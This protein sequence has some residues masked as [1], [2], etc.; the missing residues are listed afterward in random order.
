MPPKTK[1]QRLSSTGILFRISDTNPVKN[2]PIMQVA[3][4]ETVLG[5]LTPDCQ[6]YWARITVVGTKI[7]EMTQ[8]VND[9]TQEFGTANEK[10]ILINGTT[11]PVE[12]AV[13]FR[14]TLAIIIACANKHLVEFRTLWN[15]FHT[16]V[17]IDFLE[18]EDC[19]RNGK[20]YGIRTGYKVIVRDD[21]LRGDADNAFKRFHRAV[22]LARGL[23]RGVNCLAL[24]TCDRD[25][26]NHYIGMLFFKK[27][28][29]GGEG[30]N[31]PPAQLE[32]GNTEGGAKAPQSTESSASN[33][34]TAKPLKA[35]KAAK[36]KRAK[37]KSA[38]KTTLD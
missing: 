38:R 34:V 9:L 26:A 3:F 19:V 6:K 4:G 32:D 18:L 25:A 7:D 37:K 31:N 22:E 8:R 35:K 20:Q 27:D 24:Q 17:E 30:D 1:Q 11:L 16:L 23:F 33:S 13:A 29:E 28:D 21:D 36:K 14:A 5:T 12:T 2:D 10:S 15:F